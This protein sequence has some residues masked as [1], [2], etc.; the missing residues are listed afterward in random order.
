MKRWKAVMV[1]S[2]LALMIGGTFALAQEPSDEILP[3]RARILQILQEY[4]EVW[5]EIQASLELDDE[6]GFFGRMR[7]RIMGQ[8]PM[9]RSRMM[10]RH[11]MRVYNQEGYGP[12]MGPRWN[13]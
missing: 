6:S 7:S 10:G 13:R 5:E 2:L 4:P 9:T 11:H 3:P 12:R 1:L 8:E